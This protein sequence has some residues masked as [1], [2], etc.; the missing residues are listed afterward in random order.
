M[1][2]EANDRFLSMKDLI[3]KLGI[4]KSTIYN[5]IKSGEFPSGK[6]IS[7][8]RKGWLNSQVNEWMRLR[9]H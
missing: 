9:G 1:Q 5:L 8:Q 3:P 6:Q 2:T 4:C 7:K